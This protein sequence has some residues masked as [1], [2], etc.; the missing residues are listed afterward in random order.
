VC[1]PQA[2]RY[3]HRQH[4]LH[5]SA[6]DRR[7]A[8]IITGVRTCV[9]DRE[10]QQDPDT[11]PASCAAGSVPTSPAIGAAIAAAGLETHERDSLDAAETTA[12]VTIG[13]IALAFALGFRLPRQARAQSI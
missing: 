4:R 7:Q 6:A 10:S 9:H 5:R 2:V 11:V 1:D 3:R 13:L 8:Q 12:L